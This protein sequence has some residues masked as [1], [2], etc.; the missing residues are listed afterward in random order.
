MN[1]QKP[2]PGQASQDHPPSAE[3]FF[4]TANA[5]QQTAALKG[6]VELDVFTI[7]G[8][9]KETAAEIAKECHASERG[10]R[11]LCDYLC[12]LGFLIKEGARYGLTH[13]SSVFLDRQSPAYMGGTLDFLLSPHLTSNFT[14]V[15]ALVRHDGTLNPD[16]GTLAPENPAWVTFARAMIPMTTMPAQS[17]AQLVNGDSTQ[18]IKV[19]DIAAGHGVFGI[20]FAK[21]NLNS[22]IVAQDWPNVLE[23]AKENAQAAGVSDRYSTIP[24]N[25]FDVSFGRGYDVVLLTNF[26]HHFDPPTCEQLLQKVH[27]ALNEGGR[28][29]TLDFIPNPDRVSPPIPATFAM[30]ML[31]TTP[32]G[33]TYTFGEFER[34]FASAGFKQSE[35]RSL[36]PSPQQIVISYK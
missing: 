26:L 14:D 25:A 21:V 8:Q 23:V 33:D 4:R 30:T 18:S 29:V 22:Q 2:A 13:D 5:Y 12:V 6:A 3:L 17:M 31:G 1:S 7:I 27:A 36:P 32:H 34:M 28:V 10:V 35:L 19:L 15:A 16:G 9:G 20:E 24:G 11:I